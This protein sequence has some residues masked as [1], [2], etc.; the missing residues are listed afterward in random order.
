M[1]LKKLKNKGEGYKRLQGST[2]VPD[3][4]ATDSNFHTS[5][6][7]ASKSNVFKCSRNFANKSSDKAKQREEPKTASGSRWEYESV[8]HVPHIV[9]R[10]GVSF[11]NKI[12]SSNPSVK[13]GCGRHD[14]FL[15]KPGA[16][17]GGGRSQHCHDLRYMQCKCCA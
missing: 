9:E 4:C 12:F 14:C 8:L 2:D 15:C 6:L 3:P 1:R 13:D 11:K 16:P 10:V 17:S 5:T 7:V